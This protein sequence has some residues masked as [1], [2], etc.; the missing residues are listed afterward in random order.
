MTVFA[1]DYG[2]FDVFKHQRIVITENR[3]KD[4]GFV[5]AQVGRV[6]YSRGKTIIIETTNKRLITIFPIA[7]NNHNLY[8]PIGPFYASTIFTIQGQTL[9]HASVWFDCNILPAGSAYVAV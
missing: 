2:D 9:D 1:K 5:N 3:N 4:I 6:K 8:Y 7:D